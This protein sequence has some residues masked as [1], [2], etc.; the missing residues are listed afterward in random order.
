MDKFVSCNKM[1]TSA[2]GMEKSAE[3]SSG[4]CGGGDVKLALPLEV[5]RGYH[6][7]QQN[8]NTEKR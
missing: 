8:N 3:S 2:C 1:L 5:R 7:K 4:V 6:S